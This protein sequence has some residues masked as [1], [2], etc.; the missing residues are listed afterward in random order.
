[1][2]YGIIY[3]LFS[4]ALYTVPVSYKQAGRTGF[5]FWQ[6]TSPEFSV[7]CPLGCVWL[8][9]KSRKWL[10]YG[11]FGQLCY[12]Q[13]ALSTLF[14]T[15]HVK[16]RVRWWPRAGKRGAMQEVHKLLLTEK[17]ICSFRL[18]LYTVVSKSAFTEAYNSQNAPS[19]SPCHNRSA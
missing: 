10:S 15:G 12:N 6:K 5:E 18:Y 17:K 11:C 19:P 2:G 16:T 9:F 7:I 4:R 3:L 8:C 13:A 14:W 1:M